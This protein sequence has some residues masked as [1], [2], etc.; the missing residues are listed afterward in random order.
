MI[1]MKLLYVFSSV[2]HKKNYSLG[3]GKYFVLQD[4]TLPLRVPAIESGVAIEK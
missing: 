2:Q 1:Q 3:E 4:I